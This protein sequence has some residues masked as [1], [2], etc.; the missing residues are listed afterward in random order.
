MRLSRKHAG[1]RELHNGRSNIPEELVLRERFLKAYVGSDY[2][3]HATLVWQ[4]PIGRTSSLLRQSISPGL[5]IGLQELPW[6]RRE[7]YDSRHFKR[8][9]PEFAN[10]IPGDGKFQT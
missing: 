3:R 5:M 10:S 1:N 7:H 6:R 8:W 4:R 9:L 2:G